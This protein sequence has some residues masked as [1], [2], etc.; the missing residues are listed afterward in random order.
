[1]TSKVA[2][3]L[4]WCSFFIF[5]ANLTWKS[6]WPGCVHQWDS[7]GILPIVTPFPIKYFVKFLSLPSFLSFLSFHIPKAVTSHFGLKS[8]QFS[9]PI[10]WNQYHHY[11]SSIDKL[12]KPILKNFLTKHLLSTYTQYQQNCLFSFLLLF[13]QSHFNFYLLLS[14]T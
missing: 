2:V 12:T 5:F 8:L 6:P 3:S 14:I 10:L 4:T 9:G 7:N 1:M 13:S 11:F